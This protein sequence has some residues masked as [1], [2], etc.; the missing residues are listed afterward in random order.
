MTIKYYEHDN[1]LILLEQITIL[2]KEEYKPGY[3]KVWYRKHNA[4]VRPE[5]TM[6]LEGSINQFIITEE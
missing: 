3:M 2:K 6:V 1:R 4:T 5:D